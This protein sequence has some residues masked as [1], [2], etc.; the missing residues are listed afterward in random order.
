MK[1]TRDGT[2][3]RLP[4]LSDRTNKV[5]QY[6]SLAFF[7]LAVINSR[8]FSDV[9]PFNIF[10]HCAFGCDLFVLFCPL[11]QFQFYFLLFLLFDI[12]HSKFINWAYLFILKWA[13]G[14]VS[15]VE[16]YFQKNSKQG[17]SNYVQACGFDRRWCTPVDRLL[18]IFTLKN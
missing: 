7:H 13:R 9:V 3:P 12:L 6:L 2:H 5:C 15:I 4:Q 11:D 14:R 16:F 17:Q 10:K 8:L 18:V 1:G